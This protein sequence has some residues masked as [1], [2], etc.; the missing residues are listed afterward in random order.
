[1]YGS[2]K[3]SAQAAARQLCGQCSV[4]ASGLAALKTR[5]WLLIPQVTG[6]ELAPFT[7]DKQM[8]LLA[9]LTRAYQ[10]VNAPL[11]CLNVTASRPASSSPGRR[12]APSTPAWRHILS[13]KAARSL[14]LLSRTRN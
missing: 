12:Q 13:Y 14:H 8:L 1:M 9:A 11:V 7:D 6:S 2:R 4:C 3:P 10:R 5:E